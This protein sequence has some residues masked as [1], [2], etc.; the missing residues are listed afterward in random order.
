MNREI[1]LSEVEIGRLNDIET[2]VA[3]TLNDYSNLKLIVRGRPRYLDPQLNGGDVRFASKRGF[4]FTALVPN[5]KYP[6]A[7]PSFKD[8][9]LLTLESRPG[10]YQVGCLIRVGPDENTGELHIIKDLIDSASIETFDNLAQNYETGDDQNVLNSVTLMGSPGSFFAVSAPPF[11]RKILLI[12][13]WYK[14]VPGDS[15]ML[16]PTPDVLDSLTDFEVTRC[17][18]L[19]TRPGNGIEPAVVYRYEVEVNTNS[20]LIP[21]VPT[22]GLTLYLKALPMYQRG[23]FGVGDLAIPNNVGPFLVDVFSGG[24][25]YNHKVATKIGIKTWDSFGTQLNADLTN[26]QEWQQIATNYLMLERP[27]RSDTFIF[28]QRIQGFFQLLKGGFFQAQ[29][30]E[31]GEFIMSSDL[32][33]PKWPTDRQHGWV[34]P[35]ISQS[36]LT[37]SVQFEPQERQYFEVPSSTLF[38][39][40]PKLLV[41]PNRTPIDRIIIAMKGS[42]NSRVEMRTWEYDGPA[43]QALS[44]YMLATQ[45]AFGDD[46]WLG[47]GFSVKPLFFNLDVLKARYSDGSSKYNSGYVYV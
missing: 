25:L 45:A 20:T 6:L 47:G 30:D 18:L 7:T 36:P 13:S 37:V 12:E 11:E 1:F 14:M 46:R 23:D 22:V 40:R 10:W 29:L 42:P 35:L 5:N 32:L 19:G 34:I 2:L 3:G 38:F 15:L 31:N 4:A 17:H 28:W 33:V 44:Y 21:F 26:N 9:N 41:D 27:I 43:V 24:L 16:S 39:I 8:N